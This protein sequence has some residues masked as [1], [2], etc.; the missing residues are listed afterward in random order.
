VRDRSVLRRLV[1]VGDE[2]ATTAL[3]PQGRET[4]TILDE[5]ESKVFRIAEEGARGRQG[6]VEIEGLLTRVSSALTSCSRRANR[7]T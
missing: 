7:R 5:A 3:N 6:F 1:S 4:K 2:I